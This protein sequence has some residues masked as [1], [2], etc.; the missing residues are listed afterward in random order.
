MSINDVLEDLNDPEVVYQ[1]VKNTVDKIVVV[2][3]GAPRGISTVSWVKGIPDQI[4]KTIYDENNNITKQVID[5]LKKP[6]GLSKKGHTPEVHICCSTWEYDCVDRY[7][8]GEDNSL[9][10]LDLDMWNNKTPVTGDN[11]PGIE[12]QDNTFRINQKFFNTMLHPTESNVKIKVGQIPIKKDKFENYLRNCFKWADSVNFSYTDPFE[13]TNSWESTWRTLGYN[14]S[15][16]SPKWTG[17]MLHYERAYRD[18]IDLFESL[19][20]NSVV[21]RIRW[22]SDLRP[23]NTLWGFAENILVTKF[24]NHHN[25]TLSHNMFYDLYDISPILLVQHGRIVRGQW[26]AVDYWH[27]FDGEGAKILGREWSNW[28]NADPIKRM[29]GVNKF[30]PNE[31]WNKRTNYNNQP[32][33]V[34]SDFF[35]DHDFTVYELPLNDSLQ[36][37]KTLITDQWRYEWYEWTEE[38]VKDLC[39]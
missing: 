3:V 30:N 24:R 18:N 5:R 27:G 7:V 38:M 34:F 8:I 17:Q 37:F 2:L 22:D 32:E 14:V 15:I 25:K 11:N 20:R 19:T 12:I 10:G 4:R 9:G 1:Y 28:I 36:S 13:I 29:P 35:L 23:A 31:P 39:S 26:S 16:D 21:L 6:W 33:S